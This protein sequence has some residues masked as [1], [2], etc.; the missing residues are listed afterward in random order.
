MFNILTLPLPSWKYEFECHI[1]PIQIFNWKKDELRT[2]TFKRGEKRK[3]KRGLQQRHM[4]FEVPAAYHQL[5]C[6]LAAEIE[7]A[8]GHDNHEAR[9]RQVYARQILDH[10]AHELRQLTGYTSVAMA[11]FR[12]KVLTPILVRQLEGIHDTYTPL[13]RQAVRGGGENKMSIEA[14]TKFYLREDPTDPMFIPTY[15]RNVLYLPIV[16]WFIG[17]AMGIPKSGKAAPIYYNLFIANHDTILASLQAEGYQGFDENKIPLL[18]Q[19]EVDAITE[20][21]LELFFKPELVSYIL[22]HH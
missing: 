2:V 17:R 1:T 18:T 5:T 10:F 13:I 4:E 9:R 8:E 11:R 15:R 22:F 19:A 12:S 14:A 16:R 21:K 20:E 6:Q 7:F 3:K